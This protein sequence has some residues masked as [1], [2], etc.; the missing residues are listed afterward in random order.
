M[1]LTVLGGGGV[2]SPFLAK[3]LVYSAKELNINQI[4]FMDND[5]EK[6]TIYGGLAKKVANAIN[7]N[8]EFSLTTNAVEAVNAADYVI[9]TLRVGQ[10]E[11]RYNDEKIAQK[12]GI[13]GQ[14]TTGVGGF[15]MALRSIPTLI[16][17]CKL[18]Q[19][20]ANPEVLVF[21]FTN[22]SGL[23]TQ[24]LRN[25]GFNNVYGICDGPFHFIKQLENMLGISEE[26]FD[27][28]CYGLNHLSF[29]REPRI[30]GEDATDIVIN[31]EKL[32][33]DTEMKIF[34]KQLISILS[35]ELPNEYLYF[36]FY[37]DKVINS[38][39]STGFARG[40]LIRNINKRMLNEMKG[41]DL[42][43]TEK[44]FEVYIRHLAEREESYFSIESG[45]KR[46][47][48]QL[49]TFEQFVNTPDKG[50]YAGIA[51]N[52][53]RAFHG[54]V[55]TTMTLLIP[56]NESIDGLRDDDVVEITCDIIG[57]KVSPRKVNNIPSIQLQ[58]IKT[59]KL[60]ERLTVEAIKERSKEKAI[61]ALMIHPL[62]NSYNIA[63]L[64]VE[65][66]LNMY[67]EY[68]GDWK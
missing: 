53:I 14:E 55:K 13:L 3:S 27:I 15:A 1:K 68:V 47:D 57:G 58:L 66:Y 56:N 37:N 23:V 6:L 29:F 16:E 10:D 43:N 44:T 34:D 54:N 40:E 20:K 25:E 30:N 12:Y 64:I 22:P 11:G 24:A 33:T 51:L 8:V 28:T 19:E 32:F 41:I 48:I 39:K 62:V 31:H 65:E 46:L 52:C 50:G 38:I 67:R 45:V 59:I 18:I 63:R 9:T 36:Y 26:N 61:K 21:N 42:E 60:F 4:V 2:R 35:N 17:Y 7:P 5:E 49:P